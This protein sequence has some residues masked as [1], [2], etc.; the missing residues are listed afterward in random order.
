MIS[1]IIPVYN[2]QDYLRECLD[3]IVSQENQDYEVIL[4]DDGSTDKSPDICDEYCSRYPQFRVIHK[5]NGGVSSAR[6]IGLDEAKGDWIWFVDADD[7]IEKNALQELED[8]ISEH[9]CDIVFHGLH[10]IFDNGRIIAR[11]HDEEFKLCKKDFLSSH[12]CYQNGMLL[13]SSMIIRDNCLRYSKGMKMGEDMEFQWKYLLHCTRPIMIAHSLY[14]YRLRENSASHNTSTKKN[15]L[16]GNQMLLKHM[17]EY[18]KNQDDKG[19]GWMGQRMVSR[20][21]NLIKAAG[22]NPE[23]K[24]SEFQKQVRFYID[25]FRKIGYPEFN[26]KTMKLTYFDTR[27]YYLFYKMMIYINRKK[28]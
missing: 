5:K 15:S 16:Y 2:V 28:K 21:K 18:I 25:E 12:D 10:T 7:W 27:L 9:D 3:S 26:S 22:N 11:S 23:T 8:V 14:Y 19:I 24:H 13:F 6:N 1:I 20:V 17:L 4:V